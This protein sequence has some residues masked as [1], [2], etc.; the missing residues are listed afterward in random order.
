MIEVHC[1]EFEARPRRQTTFDFAN[2]VLSIDNVDEFTIDIPTDIDH[3]WTR[4]GDIPAN[5][6]LGLYVIADEIAVTMLRHVASP[7]CRY[8]RP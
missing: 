4:L 6:Q 7:L 5:R 2:G 8:V 1:E 3:V